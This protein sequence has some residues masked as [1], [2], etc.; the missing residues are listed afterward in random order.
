MAAHVHDSVLQ[1]LALIQ[2]SSSDASEVTRLARAQ[3]RELR[4]WLFDGIKPGSFDGNPASVSLAL[5]GIEGEVE[6]GHGVGVETVIVG[7]CLLDDALR[8]LLAAGREAIVNAAKWS[9][10]S[11]VSV[12]VEV[13][14]D[15]VSMFVRDHGRGF[16]PDGLPPDRNGICSVDRGTHDSIRRDRRISAAS[17]ASGQK[18]NCR[19]LESPH[20]E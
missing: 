12:F 16:D 8:A 4:S 6:D 20:R 1:T 9:G 7:D 18:S 19:C 15:S 5:H 14:S 17:S 10:E 13:N 3:E 11:N 2:K